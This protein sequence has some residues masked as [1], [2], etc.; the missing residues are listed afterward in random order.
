MLGRAQKSALVQRSASANRSHTAATL[1]ST[2]GYVGLTCLLLQTTFSSFRHVF[3]LTMSLGSLGS[4]KLDF[5]QETGCLTQD[6]VP[7]ITAL[8]LSTVSSPVLEK[9]S[10]WGEVGSAGLGMEVST[11]VKLAEA[12]GLS[13]C[14]FFSV[15]GTRESM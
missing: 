15:T 5:F 14:F 2:Q 7:A 10:V 3:H 12:R 11:V 6:P 8:L 9:G 1:V 4:W 13:F